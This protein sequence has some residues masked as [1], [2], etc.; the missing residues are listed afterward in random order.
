MIRAVP[1]YQVGNQLD[2][3]LPHGRGR[4]ELTLTFGMGFQQRDRDGSDGVRIDG[5]AN[6]EDRR[7]DEDPRSLVEVVAPESTTTGTVV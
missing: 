3:G 5:K 6:S 2:L 7:L 1:L 4:Q